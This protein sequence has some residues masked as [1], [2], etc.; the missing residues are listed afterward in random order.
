MMSASRSTLN[1]SAY[2][3]DHML[4]S[5]RRCLTY[6]LVKDANWK[7]MSRVYYNNRNSVIRDSINGPQPSRKWLTDLSKCDKY[8]EEFYWTWRHTK[9]SQ[10]CNVLIPVTQTLESTQVYHGVLERSFL[11][12]VV[13]VLLH[14]GCK[15]FLS[16]I[17]FW[18][19]PKCEIFLVRLKELNKIRTFNSFRVTL[20]VSKL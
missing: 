1:I 2:I 19:K 8:P 3:H 7:H 17:Y 18:V 16:V 12:G 6:V 10:A 11:T 13:K 15:I 4:R 5:R 20:W 9:L 14:R